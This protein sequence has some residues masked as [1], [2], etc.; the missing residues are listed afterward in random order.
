MELAGFPLIWGVDK[1]SSESASR[2]SAVSGQQ[3]ESGGSVK[4]TTEI[5]RVA[6]ND[7]LEGEE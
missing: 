3:S 5:L 4:T 2:R 7:G 6:Q 1:K